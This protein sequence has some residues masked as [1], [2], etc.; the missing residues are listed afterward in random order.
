VPNELQANQHAAA[1]ARLSLATMA[2]ANAPRYRSMSAV[3][4]TIRA[5]SHSL[6][7]TLFQRR[8]MPVRT[9]DERLAAAAV[10]AAADSGSDYGDIN[11]VDLDAEGEAT[12][13]RIDWSSLRVFPL[14]FLGMNLAYWGNYLL[15][16]VDFASDVN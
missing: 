13:E 6:K 15:R 8:V 16:S 12:L 3:V 14:C 9:D 5:M 1:A 2:L 10:A 11:D 7:S 4:V